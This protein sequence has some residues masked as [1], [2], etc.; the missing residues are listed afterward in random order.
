MNMEQV[1]SLATTILA[2]FGGMLAGWG[3][4]QGGFVLENWETISGVLLTIV[5]LAYKAFANRTAGVVQAAAGLDQVEKVVVNDAE[6]AR[7][8]TSPDARVTTA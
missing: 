4:M 5:V 8:T 7:T 6:L 3:S 2:S 1:K